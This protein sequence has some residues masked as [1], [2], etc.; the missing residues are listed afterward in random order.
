MNRQE[1]ISTVI[2]LAALA[3]AVL[4]GPGPVAQ[5]ETKSVTPPYT[6][7]NRGLFN[8][9]RLQPCTSA[10]GTGVSSDGRVGDAYSGTLEVSNP[11]NGAAPV[12]ISIVYSPT[13][14]AA[15]TIRVS[16]DF[17]F[18]SAAGANPAVSVSFCAAKPATSAGPACSA[19]TTVKKILLQQ[20]GDQN[21]TVAP[22]HAV[23]IASGVFPAGTLVRAWFR[24]YATTKGNATGWVAASL[25]STQVQTS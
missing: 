12:E 11:P 15:S 4:V 25:Q 10:A 24:S 6:T 16:G 19:P 3:V 1:R 18:L 22:I 13:T 17:T 20:Q 7:C 23:A 14:A 5:A 9:P 8:L 2:A 21:P